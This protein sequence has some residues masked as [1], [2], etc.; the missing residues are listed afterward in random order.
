MKKILAVV[1]AAAI[2][3]AAFA[4]ISFGAR[5]SLGVSI[6]SISEDTEKDLGNAVASELAA[7]AEVASASYSVENSNRLTGGFSFWGNYSLPSLPALGFQAELGMLFGN[8]TEITVESK[9][10]GASMEIT[11]NL[12]YTTLEFPLLVTYTLN[13]G[14]FF[15]FIPQAGFYLSFPIGKAKEDIDASATV[16]GSKVYDESESDDSAIDSHVLVGCLFGA[17]FALNFN[18][19]S[20]LMFNARYIFDFNKLKIED[21]EVARRSA[22][23]MSIGYRHTL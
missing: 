1:A 8:G 17:D 14:G 16:A 7:A 22:F 15:E 2:S 23:L 6:L 21:E 10:T 11:E 20:A 4:Q 18:R 5:G 13:K 3:S 9:V 19:T 12:S